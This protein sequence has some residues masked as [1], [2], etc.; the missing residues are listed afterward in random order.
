MTPRIFVVED[1]C[2]VAL[3]IQS[4]L[5]KMGY[6]MA[7]TASSGEDAML[8]VGDNPPDVILMD[9]HLGSGID[10]V[11]AA[12][13]IRENFRIPVVFITA[14]A[15]QELISRIRLTEPFA[16]VLKPFE[17][18]ELHASIEIALL[19]HRLEQELYEQ[20]QLLGTTLDSIGDGVIVTGED[21]RIRFMNPI[22]ETLTGWSQDE[23]VNKELAAVY[24]VREPDVLVARDGTM[25]KVASR[26]NL[27]MDSQGNWTG[28]VHA[29]T[30]ITDREAAREALH[31]RELEFRWLMEHADR[32]IL[33]S[34]RKG[35]IL[36][37]NTRMCELAGYARE[38]LLAMHTTDLLYPGPAGAD[39]P[40]FTEL[41]EDQIVWG[42]RK[43]VRRDAR[44]VQV[45]INARGLSDG[46]I[47]GVLHDISDRKKTQE[48]LQRDAR[49]KAV[50]RLMQELAFLTEGGD[51][52]PV[53]HQLGMDLGALETVRTPG[54][55]AAESGAMFLQRFRLTVKAFEESV[56]SR[57]LLTGTLLTVLD[58]DRLQANGHGQAGNAGVHMADATVVLRAILP[59]ILAL[60]GSGIETE[61]LA[62][63]TH[64]ASDA[65]TDIS[66]GIG[67]ITETVQRS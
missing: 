15:D 24:C 54:T 19:R 21:G 37:V 42:E 17:E 64:Q 10:G 51:G 57:L 26:S 27:M 62:K 29:F 48:E 5:R 25:R 9:V 23:A 55:A 47:H 2:I 16:Y 35:R 1:E 56:A 6:E 60:S 14:Y 52:C 38:E 20:K 7:G 45:E 13:R 44:V 4:R 58:G 36:A 49:S 22:A 39:D 31:H 43:L 8:A 63:L 40:S 46:R 28:F 33:I 11:E 3:D 41:Q 32:A 53:L 66:R 34:N 12:A 67:E 59:E 65:L 61:R 18:S 50:E 30:D